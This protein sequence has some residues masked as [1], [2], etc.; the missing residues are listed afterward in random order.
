MAAAQRST[1]DRSTSSSDRAERAER[2]ERSSR[3][4]S[5][6]SSRKNGSAMTKSSKEVAVANSL[7]QQTV[8]TIATASEPITTPRDHGMII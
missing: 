4:S 6:A 2:A 8:T 3:T 5:S 1:V 7:Q